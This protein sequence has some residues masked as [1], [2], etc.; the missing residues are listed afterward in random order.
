VS[1]DRQALAVGAAT[2]CGFAGLGAMLLFQAA[3]LQPRD[4]PLITWFGYAFWYGAPLVCGSSWGYLRRSPSALPLVVLSGLA[5]VVSGVLN[6]LGYRIGVVAVP[7]IPN[8]A[9]VL[10]F[11]VLSV[12]LLTWAGAALGSSIRRQGA[13]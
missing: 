1:S 13:A 7:R 4:R 10:G 5:A 9:F 3:W 6:M 2:L 8:A 11:A 12:A